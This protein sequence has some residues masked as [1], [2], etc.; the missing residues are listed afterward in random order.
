[1]RTYLGIRYLVWAL[2]VWVAVA[3]T[4]G[5][6]LLYR[7]LISYKDDDELF[8][9]PAEVRSTLGHIRHVNRMASW[10][11]VASAVSLALIIAG[12]AFGLL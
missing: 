11:G 2:A 10:F 6:I 7:V 12:W 8:M 9:S 3:G 1:M 5:V 4:Y